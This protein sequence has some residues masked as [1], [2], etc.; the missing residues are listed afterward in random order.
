MFQTKIVQKIKMDL[1]FNN[2]LFSNIIPFM[3]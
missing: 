1:I 2:F 3:I